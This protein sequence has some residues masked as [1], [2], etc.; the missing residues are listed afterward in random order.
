[1][2]FIMKKTVFFTSL[3]ILIALCSCTKSGLNTFCGDYSFKTSGSVTVQRL[4][5]PMDSIT[6]AA[7]TFSLPNEIGQ[8]EIATLD[9]RND[10][11]IVIMNY[12]NGEVL[13][14]HGHCENEELTLNTFQRNALNI[15]IDSEMD[16]RTPIKV[17]GV[18]HY[19]DDNTLVF[20]MSYNGWVQLGPLFYKV[21]GDNIQMVA[22]RN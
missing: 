9:R 7:F 3:C 20:N 6:P 2:R 1:M 15:S 19:Y 5:L 13:V 11:V 16:F 14:T 22:Y 8:L 21:D 18:G 10:S 17:K 12:L 4:D